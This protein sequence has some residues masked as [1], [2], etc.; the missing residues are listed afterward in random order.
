[1]FLEPSEGRPTVYLLELVDVHI[2]TKII[3]CVK[4]LLTK[5]YIKCRPIMSLSIYF[6]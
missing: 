1:M 6:S 5:E 3:R 2:L 4:I